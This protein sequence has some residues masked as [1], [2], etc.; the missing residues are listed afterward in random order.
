MGRSAR[1]TADMWFVVIPA[2][3]NLGRIYDK[4]LLN[5]GG[6]VLKE[7]TWLAGSERSAL[8]QRP[9]D[10]EPGAYCSPSRVK[11]LMRLRR[12]PLLRDNTLISR[13]GDRLVMTDLPMRYRPEFDSSADSVLNP[14]IV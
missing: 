3:P 6:K 7:R 2:L 5:H 12:S 11:D 14:H 10:F 4:R 13:P 9:I 1:R 8:S